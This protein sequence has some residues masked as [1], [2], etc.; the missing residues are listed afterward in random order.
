MY[1]TK[2]LEWQKKNSSLVIARVMFQTLICLVPAFQKSGSKTIF[3]SFFFF[4]REY[5][6][7]DISI[8]SVL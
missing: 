8:M 6:R 1:K 3:F 4:L 5:A 7:Y 2:E